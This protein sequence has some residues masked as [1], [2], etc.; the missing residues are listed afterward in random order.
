VNSPYDIWK[1]GTGVTIKHRYTGYH[2]V[3]CEIKETAA[4]WL[5]VYVQYYHK[6]APVRENPTNL[7]FCND[8]R[9]KLDHT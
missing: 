7:E 9:K 6:D 3:V 4:E 8:G 2:G 5:E 1:H